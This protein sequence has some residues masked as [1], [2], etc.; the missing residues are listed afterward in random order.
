MQ[1]PGRPP[2]ALPPHAIAAKPEEIVGKQRAQS[3]HVPASHLGAHTEPTRFTSKGSRFCR[4]RKTRKWR[5]AKQEADRGAGAPNHHMWIHDWS[6]T[7]SISGL[8]V[9]SIVAI[10]G[11]RVR[12]T[13]DAI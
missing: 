12:F 10:D 2:L 5:I 6:T 11:P 3:A 8:V 4:W 13:A 7:S 9:K 1:T